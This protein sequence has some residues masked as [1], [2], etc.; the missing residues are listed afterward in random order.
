M[1]P[2]QKRLAKLELK[3]LKKKQ[4]N[5]IKNKI[6]Y[7]PTPEPPSPM[8]R[9]GRGMTDVWQGARNLLPEKF[10]GYNDQQKQ[11]VAIENRNYEKGF[12]TWNAS[13]D[14][15]GNIT[16]N[17]DWARIGGQAAA[18]APLMLLPAGQATAL[19]RASAGGIAGLLSGMS[20]Y[21]ERPEDQLWN[22]LFGLGG[23]AALSTLAPYVAQVGGKTYAMGKEAIK[24]T[25]TYMDAFDPRITGQITNKL[26]DSFQK[27]GI[28]L[29]DLGQEMK[30]KLILDAQESLKK[31]GTL[32]TDALARKAKAEQFGFTGDKAPTTGQLID[33][34][35]V[36]AKEYNISRTDTEAGDLLADRFRNQLGHIQGKF[37]QWQKE[38]FGDNADSLTPYRVLNTVSD[39]VETRARQLQDEVRVAYNNI[40]GGVSLNKESLYNRSNQVMKNWGDEVSSGVKRRIKEITD[41]WDHRDFTI[42]DYIELDKLITKTMKG[43]AARDLKDAI[44]GVLDDSGTSLTGR[45]KEAYLYAKGLAKDRFDQIGKSNK[46][47]SLLKEGKLDDQQILNKLKTGTSVDE[48][49]DLF[50]FIDENSKKQIRT[51]ILSDLTEKSWGTNGKAVKTAFNKNLS[52]IAPEKLEIIF[53]KNK[54]KEIKGFGDVISSF[55]EPNGGAP[56]YSGSGILGVNMVK[57]LYSGL[58]EAVSPEARLLSAFIPKAPMKDAANDMV[59]NLALQSGLPKLPPLSSVANPVTSKTLSRI[60]STAP[61][62]GLLAAEKGR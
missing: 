59:V 20:V 36:W 3:Y 32:D 14:K 54:Y 28:T 25:K 30:D 62:G 1:T 38:M 26:S 12:N 10:G 24:R 39:S 5:S 35:R 19:G 42:D 52:K 33:D 43:S 18:T 60:A 4:G 45:N 16:P 11:D 2:E 44:I 37:K 15:D 58:I 13:K 55:A 61:I 21:Q 48:T 47:V 27:I 8:V 31:T 51:L 57:Q 40:D 46:I 9:V 29:D 23:G 50:N 17:T 34:G 53:G 6:D 7:S 56:N 22:G 41:S 49:R